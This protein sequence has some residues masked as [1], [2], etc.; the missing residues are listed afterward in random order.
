MIGTSPQRCTT[1]RS[2]WP[3]A[4]RSMVSQGSRSVRESE[5]SGWAARRSRTTG[6]TSPRIAVENAVSRRWPETVPGPLVQAGLDLLEV[7]EQAGAGVDEVPAVVGEDHAAADPLEQRDAGLLLEPLDLLGDRA[8]GEAERVGGADD[9][10]VGVD[11]P[12]AGQGGE[13]DHVAMLHGSMHDHSLVL[14]G[15]RPVGWAV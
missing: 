9:G 12:E 14:H 2:L 3:V 7:G 13:V 8:R 10:A 1:P 4:T 6:A 5:R 15:R 11:G